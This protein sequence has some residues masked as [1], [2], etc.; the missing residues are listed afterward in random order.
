MK[1]AMTKIILA[2]FAVSALAAVVLGEPQSQSLLGKIDFQALFTAAPA[3]P[4]S[5]VE[6]ATRAYGPT[7]AD[8]NTAALD[9]FYTPFRDRVAS[10]RE[11][12]KPAV[13]ALP[14]HREAMAQRLTTQANGSAII[15]GMG[16]TDKI[17]EMSEEEAQQAAMKAVGDS[18]QAQ[19]GGHGEAARGTQAIMQRVMNDPAY[20]ERFE[21]MTQAEQEAEMRKAMGPTAVV[22]QHTAAEEQRSMQGTN[23][24]KAVMAR[25]DELNAIYKK[26]LYVDQEF[27]AKDEAITKTPGGYDQIRQDADAKFKKV[28]LVDA[29]ELGRVPDPAKY[30]V[31]LIEQVTRYRTRAAWELQQRTA[32]YASRRAAYKQLASEYSAW[33]KQNAPR[34]TNTTTQVMEDSSLE[35]AVRCEQELIGLAER[36]AKYSEDATTGAA[37]YEAQYR[38]TLAER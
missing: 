8:Q 14:A 35:T 26:T 24:A 2:L 29:G 9:A 15:A 13:D 12:I 37:Q 30:R 18:M 3:L 34:A 16:G 32:L 31:V 6:A 11:T 27:V 38:K 5:P 20:R 1:P 21:K 7:I 19:S 10:A 25:N 23:E 36:L 33:L 22:A 28:P 17:S 4:A